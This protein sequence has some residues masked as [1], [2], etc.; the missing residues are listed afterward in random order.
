MDITSA[1]KITIIFGKNDEKIL[2]FWFKI[3]TF[4]EQDQKIRFYF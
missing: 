3:R 1:K 4:F 2:Q